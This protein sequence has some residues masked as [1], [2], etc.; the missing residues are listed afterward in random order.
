[1]PTAPDHLP[2]LPPCLP[3]P[4]LHPP[5]DRACLDMLQILQERSAGLG[6]ARV[7]SLGWGC[8]L[9]A[10]VPGQE[11]EGSSPPCPE[12]AG[13]PRLGGAARERTQMGEGMCVP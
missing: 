11:H 7:W 10:Q 9:P 6:I 8:G 1:M 4:P 2:P 3:P 13:D 12:L 5:N